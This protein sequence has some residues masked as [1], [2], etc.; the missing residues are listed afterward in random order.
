MRLKRLLRSALESARNNE[1]A[2]PVRPGCGELAELFRAEGT[3]KLCYAEGYEMLLGPRRSSI[4]NV[5]EVGIGT[6][7]P[8]VHSSMDGWGDAHYQPGG[9][10]RAW[11]DYFPHARIVGI[12]VQPDTQFTSDRITT[13]ICDSTD[14]A[15]AR[16][17]LAGQ[18]KFDLVVDDGSHLPDDQLATLA[19][20]FPGIAP[21]GLYLIEDIDSASPL[22]RSP[23]MVEPLI[24][25]ALYM[26]MDYSNLRPDPGKIIVIQTRAAD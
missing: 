25:S 12:D 23:Q 14:A 1:S 4:A 24:G 15:A 7:I 13:A 2:Y 6:R 10:L 11:R 3:D 5:L 16:Q 19:N 18:P 22:Y 8:N 17:F 21:G 26:T 20:L 9:S